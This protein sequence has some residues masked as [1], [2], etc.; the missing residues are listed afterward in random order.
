MKKNV[1]QRYKSLFDELDLKIIQLLHKK[2]MGVLEIT[3][4]LNVEHKTSKNHIDKL[5]S[6]QFI[7]VEDQPQNKKLLK[8]TDLIEGLINTF[9]AEGFKFT[10][11]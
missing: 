5:I 8:L 2:D 4:H 1:G 7:E 9:N 3:K 6:Y 10:S 11:L